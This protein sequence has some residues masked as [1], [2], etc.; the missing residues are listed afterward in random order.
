MAAAGERAGGNANESYWYDA[1]KHD[2][3]NPD[4]FKGSMRT[5]RRRSGS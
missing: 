2:H 4:D 3:L 1:L 5:V